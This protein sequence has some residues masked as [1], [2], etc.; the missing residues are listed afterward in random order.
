MDTS[1]KEDGFTYRAPAPTPAPVEERRKVED[2]ATAQGHVGRNAW[3]LAAAKA[4]EGWPAG[5]EITLG[6]YQAA[7]DAAVNVPM[8]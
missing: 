6:A 2:W 4:H 7:V 5:Y 1:N 3:M 8:R